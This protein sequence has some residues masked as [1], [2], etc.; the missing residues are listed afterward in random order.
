VIDACAAVDP[1]IAQLAALTSP[2]AIPAASAPQAEGWTEA[3][4]VSNRRLFRA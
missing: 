3:H 1:F 2:D 4:A